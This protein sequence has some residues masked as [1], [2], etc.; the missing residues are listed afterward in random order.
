MGRGI[1]GRWGIMGH[2]LIICI[3]SQTIDGILLWLPLWIVSSLSIKMISLWVF[4]LFH[5]ITLRV[6]VYAK[7]ECYFLYC[8]SNFFLFIHPTNHNES[9]YV[10]FEF[11]LSTLIFK[12]T[13]FTNGNT[14]IDMALKLRWGKMG[15]HYFFMRWNGSLSLSLQSTFILKTF[16][17]VCY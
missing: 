3:F 14:F 12:K 7:Q 2:F 9:L 11:G 15:H 13:Y 17:C 10:N 5:L 8:Y 6:I 16:C 4:I 1:M